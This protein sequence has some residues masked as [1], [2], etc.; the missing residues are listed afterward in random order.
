MNYD[1]SSCFEDVRL[2]F[3]CT[4]KASAGNTL[5]KILQY[6]QF[7]SNIIEVIENRSNKHKIF[8][9]TDFAQSTLS[10]YLL[11]RLHFQVKNV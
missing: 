8:R 7:R 9:H 5:G 11:Y 4:S 2:S 1:R 3:S 10:L 6:E